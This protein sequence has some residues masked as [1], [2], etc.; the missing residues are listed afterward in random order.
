M[1]VYVMCQVTD[2]R[3]I[4]LCGSCGSDKPVTW[5]LSGTYVHGNG[6]VASV[7]L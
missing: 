1:I 3:S 6:T 7:E 4:L 2:F 5:C